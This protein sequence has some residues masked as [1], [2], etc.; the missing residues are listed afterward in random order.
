MNVLIEWLVFLGLSAVAVGMAASMLLTMSMYRAG[1]ALMSSFLALAGLFVLLDADL[2]AAIQVMMNVG[3]MLVMILFMVMLMMDPGGEMMWD[4]KRKMRLSGL[5][6]L[7]MTMPRSAPADNRE[8]A[9]HAHEAAHSTEWTC[10]MHPEVRSQRPGD[11]PKCGMALVP[12]PAQGGSA[13]PTIYT[14]PMHP[15]VKQ[16]TPGT[17][18]KCGMALVPTADSESNSHEMPGMGRD[19]HHQMM[20]DMAMS[21]AQLPW[22]LALGAVTA[23]AL[24]WLLTRTAWPISGAR[25]TREAAVAVGELLLSRYMIAFEGAAFL[26]LAGIVGAVVFGIRDV[27]VR[28][29]HGHR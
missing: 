24:I 4:M 17:C 15:E 12:R 14:C 6:A 25:P 23:A 9:S 27:A 3:G 28:H 19:Q 5:G 10:P 7:S 1:L 22:A 20:V 13:A 8:T 21:T 2:L 29:K 18:P 16:E 26:I 11:C